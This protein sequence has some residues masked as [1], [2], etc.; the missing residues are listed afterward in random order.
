MHFTSHF[1][2]AISKK[3]GEKVISV[4]VQLFRHVRNIKSPS[5]AISLELCARCGEDDCEKGGGSVQNYMGRA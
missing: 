3:L 2:W 1:T 5:V 4:T